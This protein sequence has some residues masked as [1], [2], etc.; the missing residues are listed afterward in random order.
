MRGQDTKAEDESTHCIS[1]LEL[2]E[3]ATAEKELMALALSEPYALD[4]CSS[5]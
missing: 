4:A 3:D 2:G 1:H 5:L